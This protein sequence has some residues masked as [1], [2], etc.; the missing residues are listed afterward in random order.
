MTRR[1]ERE[2]QF[3]GQQGGGGSLSH[4]LIESAKQALRLAL[5][6]RHKKVYRMESNHYAPNA[7]GAIMLLVTY[8]DV[9]MNEVIGF[10]NIFG[11]KDRRKE[12]VGKP[13]FDKFLALSEFKKDDPLAVDL[14]ALIDLRD[15][16]V[17]YLPRQIEGNVPVWFNTL[18]NKGLF[19]ELQHSDIV[20]F[21]FC[22]RHVPT[23]DI[24]GRQ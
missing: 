18:R 10:L 3:L 8:L 17:H 1:K 14:R 13:S 6:D 24:G 9:S 16:I 15:E 21:Q 22:P 5:E 12:L 23:V 11:R 4:D 20:D 7:T 19:I 2:A